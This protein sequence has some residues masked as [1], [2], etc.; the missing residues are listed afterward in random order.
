MI[1]RLE[2]SKIHGF[3]G[4]EVEIGEGVYFGEDVF[5]FVFVPWLCLG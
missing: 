2:W 3:G 5:V 1:F 4:L